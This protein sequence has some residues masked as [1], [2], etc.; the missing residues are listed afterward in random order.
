MGC[1]TSAEEKA[2]VKA[3]KAAQKPLSIFE[4]GTKV[5]EVEV[6]FSKS[7]GVTVGSKNNSNEAAQKDSTKPALTVGNNSDRP[8]STDGPKKNPFMKTTAKDYGVNTEVS[9]APLYYSTTDSGAPPERPSSSSL[10]NSPISRESSMKKMN[11]LKLKAKQQEEVGE[12]YYATSDSPPKVVENESGS[13]TK[14]V[15]KKVNPL[16]KK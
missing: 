14:L 12:L 4:N 10:S 13:L 3:A 7:S 1:T 2:K 5:Q 16:A 9:N 15:A 8:L 6:N 11:P